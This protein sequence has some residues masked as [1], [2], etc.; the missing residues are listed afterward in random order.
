MIRSWTY[1]GKC[2]CKLND[3][4]SG[5]NAFQN[6]HTYSCTEILSRSDNSMTVTIEE[7]QNIARETAEKDVSIY[8]AMAEKE[9]GNIA[10]K[11]MKFEEALKHYERAVYFDPKEIVYLNNLAA[12]F[13]QIGRM[14]D[15]LTP[16]G[17]LS[18]S[19]KKTMQ[20]P[21]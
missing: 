5:E 9:K 3:F 17:K 8:R 2:Y 13:L 14:R 4:E 19:E 7:A 10:F 16:A 18:R 15:V 12:V 1:L 20:I 21:A 11:S 6:A